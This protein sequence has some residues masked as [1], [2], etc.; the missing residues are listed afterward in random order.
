MSL[1]KGCLLVDEE[2][3]LPEQEEFSKVLEQ[4]TEE[5]LVEERLIPNWID[6]ARKEVQ[7]F[8]G[9]LTGGLDSDQPPS[10]EIVRASNAVLDYMVTVSAKLLPPYIMPGADGRML[11]EWNANQYTLDV[12]V[13]S[14]QKVAWLFRDRSRDLIEKGWLYPHFVD[15]KFQESTSYFEEAES[16]A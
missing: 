14:A 12:E 2:L 8:S 3:D 7:S 5:T 10:A 1:T 16:S 6:W 13:I 11:F 15:S 9:R 4:G